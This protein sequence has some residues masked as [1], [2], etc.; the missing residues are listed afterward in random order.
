MS[1]E[2]RF[3]V[4]RWL[5]A[6]GLAF[7]SGGALA[8]QPFPT[9][10]QVAINQLVTGVVPFTA[11]RTV[12]GSYLNWGTVQGIGGYGLR[13]NSG[14]IQV[15]NANGTWSDVQ[16]SAST[17]TAAPFIT[18]TL[19]SNLSNEFA[20]GSLATAIL[21]NTTTT[22]IPTAY[23]GTSCTNQFLTALSAAGAG[24]CATVSLS[25]VSGTLPVAN[26]GT[27]L[28]SGTSG[29]VLA[30]TASGTI[31]S[32]G[33]L[34]ANAIVLGGGAGAAP[35][36][37]G[38]LGT[39]TTVLHGNAAG[40]PTYGAV[41]LT[42]DVS[43][44]LPVA[45]GG[46]NNA[47]FT[48]SGP[49]TSAKTYTFPNANATILTD[50]SV[51]TA[52]QGGTGQ[53]SYTIGD[54]LYASG[55]TALSK[56]AGVSTGNAL[57]SGGVATA[58]SW[59]KI[60]YGTHTSGTVSATT[61]GTGLTSYTQGDILYASGTTA[62]SGLAS[63]SAGSY[64]RSTGVGANPAW[65]TLKL[66]NSAV[67]GDLLMASATDT[68]TALAD[69]STGSVLVSGGVGV[70]PAYSANPSVTTVTAATSMTTPIVGDA[71]AAFRARTN[72]AV[73]SSLAAGDW[74]VACTGVVGVNRQCVVSVRDTDGV[75]YSQNVGAVH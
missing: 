22:G 66:P 50:A 70:A 53:S 27:G 2:R 43:G 44:V 4:R 54:V 42:A 64:L 5:L 30:F 9:N 28:T 25:T 20:L 36:V 65:S 58:P 46:T 16:T 6:F 13:D 74:W 41:S 48:V 67:T 8:A 59:G 40:A 45:N 15:K 29:G 51:V 47:F 11:F 17:I 26:G 34:T 61:G 37:L 56:L 63:V 19:D 72:L 75:T 14:T 31:A 10:I 55:A 69:V 52:A 73:P 7:L 62:L 68:Y 60:V 21:V 1:K 12:A 71:S 32:S 23:A 33:A 3:E 18:R 57:I 35:T 24:T 49:A 39:T 38:S